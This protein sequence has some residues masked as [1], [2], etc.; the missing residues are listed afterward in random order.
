MQT[1]VSDK[2]L[3]ADDM[4]Q[5]AKTETKCKSQKHVYLGSVLSRA[6]QIDDVVTARAAKGRLRGIV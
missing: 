5:N 2:L 3:N 4:A 1:E 6:V